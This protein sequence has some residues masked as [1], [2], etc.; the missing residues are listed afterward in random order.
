MSDKD[1]PRVLLEYYLKRLRLPTMLREYASMAELCSQDRS[2]FTTYLLRLAEREVLDREK[3]AAER[4]IR[5]AKF[6]VIKTID[7]FEF[8]TQLEKQKIWIAVFFRR[9]NTRQ[10]RRWDSSI[11]RRVQD[12]F[13][14]PLRHAGSSVLGLQPRMNTCQHP[15]AENSA[16]RKLPVTLDS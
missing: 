7:T 15:I 5:E 1:K 16:S 3:R 6:P 10:D 12:D 8:S 4:R 9:K 2:D 11:V 13:G 14:M